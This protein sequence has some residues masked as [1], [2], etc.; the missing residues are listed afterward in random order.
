MTE[1]D[2]YEPPTFLKGLW[3][4]TL[5][6]LIPDPNSPARDQLHSLEVV[7]LSVRD[8]ERYR[9]VERYRDIEIYI[10]DRPNPYYGYL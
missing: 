8:R 3:K 6:F 2:T 1:D 7:S 9:D 5:L 4:D 10:E